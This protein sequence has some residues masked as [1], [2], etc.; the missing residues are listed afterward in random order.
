MTEVRYK[1]TVTR[2]SR[3]PTLTK[4]SVYGAQAQEIAESLG[5]ALQEDYSD[6]KYVEMSVP[7]TG[8]DSTDIYE[9]LLE[10]LDV[11]ALARFLNQS[12]AKEA[13]REEAT[14]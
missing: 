5:I 1:V 13:K 4:K 6:R 10:D 8:T 11:A 3:F 12:S 9:Q 7:G 14:E 2:Q